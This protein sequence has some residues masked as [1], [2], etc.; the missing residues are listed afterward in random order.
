MASGNVQVGVPVRLTASGV[1]A[2]G[3]AM[4]RTYAGLQGTQVE[5]TSI[6]GMIVG[7]FLNNHTGGTLALSTNNG[8]VAGTPIT[9]TITFTASTYGWFALPIASVNGIF[10][11]IG[12]AADIT[13]V[14]V[15]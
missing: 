11:T 5:Q 13:F 14:V 8:G 7:F 12:G 3:T 9:G 2:G 1:V 4:A 15:K 6:E 10:A